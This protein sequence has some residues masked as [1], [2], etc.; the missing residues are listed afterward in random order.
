MFISIIIIIIILWPIFTNLN[1]GGGGV[2]FN[3]C[4]YKKKLKFKIDFFSR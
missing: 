4:F 3:I 1:G 2:G